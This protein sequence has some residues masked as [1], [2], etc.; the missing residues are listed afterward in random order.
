MHT[1]RYR[2]RYGANSDETH[3][4][5]PPMSVLLIRVISYRA[6]SPR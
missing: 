3:Y 1:Q 4:S 6:I 5:L 2:E